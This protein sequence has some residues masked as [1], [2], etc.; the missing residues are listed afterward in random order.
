MYLRTAR[1]L[2][3][4]FLRSA[5]PQKREEAGIFPPFLPFFSPHFF[6]QSPGQIEGQTCRSLNGRET[7]ERGSREHGEGK[8]EPQKDNHLYRLEQT[9]VITSPPLLLDRSIA[10]SLSVLSQTSTPA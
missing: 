1:S 8:R 10:R 3:H 9:T 2:T 6:G 4:A 7:R 5:H